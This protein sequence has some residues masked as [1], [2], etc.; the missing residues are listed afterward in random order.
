M[1]SGSNR[2]NKKQGEWMNSRNE[3]NGEGL[4]I[5]F[6]HIFIYS[7]NFIFIVYRF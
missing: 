6:V 1:E 4:A 5:F 2:G 7:T 3:C